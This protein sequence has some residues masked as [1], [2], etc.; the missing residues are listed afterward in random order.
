MYDEFGGRETCRKIS[1]H[2]Y[3]RV[4]KDPLLRPLF[5]TTFTCAIEEFAAF[6][7]QFLGGPT[8][9]TQRRWWLSLHESHQRFKLDANHRDA[10]LRLMTAT[11][12]EIDIP[13]SHK[14]AFKALFDRS[15]AY[16]IN[17]PNTTAIP[18]LAPLWERQVN[19]D[20][21]VAAIRGH[22][23]TA[24]SLIDAFKQTPALFVGLL[25]HLI[26]S[27]QAIDYV[28]TSLEPSIAT[29][30]HS[31]NRTLLHEA[32][33]A[34]EVEIVQRLLQ[35][36][37]N[38]NTG[39]LYSLANECRKPQQGVSIVQALAAA[40]ADVNSPHNKQLTTPLH[41]AARRGSLEI[42]QALLAEGAHVNPRDRTGDTPL[43]RALNCKHPQLAQL[44]R[45]HQGTL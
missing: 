35:L 18:T 40:G 43:R 25:A 2:F 44:L 20:T 34:G 11:L 30:S 32:A 27:A 1:T 42:A 28:I 7:S 38:P 23:P 10:W 24:P 4:A 17:Q 45:Q 39:V 37:A 22:D 13:E 26:R 5:P 12:N 8:D 36:G 15:S 33:A 19:L 9:D 31:F 21:A 16:V 6:L 29:I 14:T 3:A 41:A